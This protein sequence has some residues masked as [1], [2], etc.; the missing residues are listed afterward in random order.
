MHHCTRE[1]FL[2]DNN[3][4]K[5]NKISSQINKNIPVTYGNRDIFISTT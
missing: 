5:Y 3:P 2:R 1:I 4:A